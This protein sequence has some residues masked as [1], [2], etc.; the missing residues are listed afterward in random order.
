MSPYFVRKSNSSSL[1][2]LLRLSI[3]K[4]SEIVPVPRED[5]VRIHRCPADQLLAPV[6]RKLQSALVDFD[7]RAVALLL[8]VI[9][10]GLDW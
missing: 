1:Q 5:L 7:I 10:S 6:P 2:A 3:G 9:A 8:I 4:H